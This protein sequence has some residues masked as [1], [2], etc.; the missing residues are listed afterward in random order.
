MLIPL[1]RGLPVIVICFIIS[2]FIASRYLKYSTPVY[3]S[4]VKIKLADMH[5]GPS[6]TM[7]FK[8]FD[9][10]AHDNKISEEV[11]L[12][13]SK[14]LVSKALEHLPSFQVT[15]YRVGKMH[16]AEMY[17]ESPFLVSFDSKTCKDIDR[18]FGIQIKNKDEFVL[19]EPSGE[20]HKGRFSDTIVL[21]CYNLVIR[22]NDSLLQARPELKV[23]D[24]YKFMIHSREKQVD[25]VISKL[26]IIELDKDI[27]IIR[28][29][30]QNP[31]PEKAAD[32]VNA[33]AKA[34]V[35]DYI[36]TKVETADI[37]VDFIEDR[38]KEVNNK[39]Q[40]SEN[41]IESYRDARNII[42][43]RQETETDLKKISELKIQLANLQMNL[44]TIDSLEKYLV[45]NEEH[46]LDLAPNFNAFTDLLSVELVKKIKEQQ[47]LKK[48]LL[49]RY[50]PEH[51]KVKVI[52]EKIRDMKE[53]MIESVRNT[54][55]NY[56]TKYNEI[57]KAIK[58][59]E[60]VFIGLP[61]KEK[62]MTIMERDFNL[63]QKIYN[64]LN[65]KRTEAEIARAAS[66]SFHRIIADG[67]VPQTPVA[68]KPVLIKIISGILGLMAGVGLVIAWGMIVPRVQDEAD[69]EKT[70]LIPFLGSIPFCFKSQDKQRAFRSLALQLQLKNFLQEKTIIALS[71]WSNN[72]GRGFVLKNV[73][74]ALEKLGYKTAILSLENENISLEELNTRLT[75]AHS[76][77]R[78]ILVENYDVKNNMESV[79]VMKA[80]DLNLWLLDT[81]HT[82]PAVLAEAD[83]LMEEYQIKNLHF[84]LN[85]NGN[86]PSLFMQIWN[87]LASLVNTILTFRKPRLSVA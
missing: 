81:R 73:V 14:V 1:W 29:S 41:A 10:F 20:K 53:Y 79:A 5:K 69:I 15:Y 67:E 11:E 84:L 40:N 60:K 2:S 87:A 78:V 23:V 13:K 25:E 9:V 45:S 52:D 42:N 16:T 33:L 80:V 8:D 71:S 19:T 30:Y 31:V 77:A 75:H 38:L 57:D 22:K 85:R 72:E 7:L 58:E 51:E 3:E 32:L 24:N 26:D 50:T 36:D 83:L 63:N 61:T 18:Y 86:R 39:L 43:I 21:K 12:I 48:D 64:F 68:P 70:S 54:H 34:Y 37:T 46:F 4:T 56:I 82:N 35:Q 55:R 27:A 44:V 62:Q 17:G 49:Q 66:L 65:E 59:A 74:P 47:S 76:D 28:I 6:S